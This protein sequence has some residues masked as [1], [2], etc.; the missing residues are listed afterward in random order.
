MNASII[1]EGVVNRVEF[2]EVLRESQD[3]SVELKKENQ[4]QYG[5]EHKTCDH[6]SCLRL[7]QVKSSGPPTKPEE[8][9][10]LTILHEKS[11]L[12]AKQSICLSA[13]EP[14]LLGSGTLTSMANLEFKWKISGPSVLALPFFLPSSLILN[15]RN[16]LYGCIVKELQRNLDKTFTHIF[17]PRLPTGGKKQ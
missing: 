11:P 2:I 9:L 5:G 3:P 7:P 14:I 10:P 15:Y 13:P 6:D 12:E 17:M 16:C 8:D 1:G 4:L